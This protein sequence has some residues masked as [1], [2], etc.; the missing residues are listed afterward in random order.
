MPTPPA[1]RNIGYNIEMKESE[2]KKVV[3]AKF[4]SKWQH[5]LAIEDWDIK[6][7]FEK[8]EDGTYGEVSTEPAH[9][10]AT[11]SLDHNKHRNEEDL[12]ETAKHELCH[13][14]HGYFDMYK[15]SVDKHITPNMSDIAGDIFSIAEEDT[16]LRIEKMIRRL[17]DG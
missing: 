6:V 9:R 12:L 1:T 7:K 4:I 11:V 3:N 14:V 16:V 10:S 2:A 8:L 5:L 15:D 13:L 17:T